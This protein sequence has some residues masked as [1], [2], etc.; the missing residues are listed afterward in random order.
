MRIA[1][2]GECVCAAQPRECLRARA[3]SSPQKRTLKQAA[4]FC[5]TKAASPP[6]GVAFSKSTENFNEEKWYRKTVFNAPEIAYTTVPYPGPG[7][8]DP[9]LKSSSIYR[10]TRVILEF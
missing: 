3:W 5:Q 6:R 10:R 9:D 1:C 8:Y 2:P 7:A 4:M